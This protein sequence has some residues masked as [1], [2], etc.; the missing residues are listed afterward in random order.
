M[1]TV[2]VLN[3]DLG[4]LHRVTVRHAGVSKRS[5]ISAMPPNRRMAYAAPNAAAVRPS[6][7]TV[8]A[9]F[10]RENSF[11]M[12][13]HAP[14]VAIMHAITEPE[15]SSV[16]NAACPRPTCDHRLAAGY[17]RRVGH[18]LAFTPAVPTWASLSSR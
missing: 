9:S 11:A 7:V 16:P 12:S 2:L 4:P 13:T 10:D 17:S 1:D 8:A 15:Y 3:A 18:P 6:A 14:I 5:Q